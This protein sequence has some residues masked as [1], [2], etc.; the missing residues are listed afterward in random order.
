MS[1]IV[2]VKLLNYIIS[3]ALALAKIYGYPKNRI[4]YQISKFCCCY[5]FLS[6]INRIVMRPKCGSSKKQAHFRLYRTRYIHT[7][8]VVLLDSDKQGIFHLK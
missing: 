8:L 5:Q 2:L 3:N 4:V 6:K 1:F 7:Y